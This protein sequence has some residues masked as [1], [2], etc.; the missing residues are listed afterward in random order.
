MTPAISSEDFFRFWAPFHIELALNKKV[1]NKKISTNKPITHNVF[2]QIIPQL[3]DIFTRKKSLTLKTTSSGFVV[4]YIVS[5]SRES[6]IVRLK[7]FGESK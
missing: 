6:N 7:F 4:I 5:R 1:K 2:Y 3:S